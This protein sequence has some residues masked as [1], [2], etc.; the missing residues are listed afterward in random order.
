MSTE[1]TETPLTEAEIFINSVE[2]KATELSNQLGVEVTPI[3][4][5]DK[6]TGEKVVGYLKECNDYNV[7]ISAVGKFLSNKTEEAAELIFSASLIK[8]ASNPRLFS[9]NDSDSKVK[10]GAVIACIPLLD[11]YANEYKKK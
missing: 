8:E 3:I 7:L 5:P 9:F 6:K 2:A 1:G 10:V 4:I 11:L